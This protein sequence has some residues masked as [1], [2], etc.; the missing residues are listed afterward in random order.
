MADKLLDQYSMSEVWQ[1]YRMQ[2]AKGLLTHR[3]ESLMVSWPNNPHAFYNSMQMEEVWRSVQDNHLDRERVIMTNVV[4]AVELC[5]KAV[6]THA[7]FREAKCFKFND[8]HDITKL[9]NALPSSLRGEITSEV[10]NV[11]QGL[12]GIQEAGRG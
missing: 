1:L 9:Y 12:F 10:R 7:S 2:E 4:Q 3:T 11:R 8:G 6:M 5:L